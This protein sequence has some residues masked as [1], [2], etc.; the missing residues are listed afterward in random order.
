MGRRE[1]AVGLVVGSD[2]EGL[3]TLLLLLEAANALE[4]KIEAELVKIRAA[5]ELTTK[6]IT[7]VAG[8]AL[9]TMNYEVW[10]PTAAP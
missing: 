8:E 4:K 5:E 3:R 7:N 9:V 1:R 6:E 10:E 2:V